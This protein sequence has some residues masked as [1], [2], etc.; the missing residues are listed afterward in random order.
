MKFAVCAKHVPAGQLRFD[1][2]SRLLDR[3]GPG[4]LNDVDRHAKVQVPVVKTCDETIRRFAQYGKDANH[5]GFAILFPD[6]RLQPKWR[7]QEVAHT[8][9]TIDPSRR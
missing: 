9:Q 3:T 8:H 5:V 4:E 7:N 6:R 1:Q 2:A